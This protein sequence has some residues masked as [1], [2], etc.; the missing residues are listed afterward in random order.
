M[1]T[2]YKNEKCTK[3]KTVRWQIE[4]A[5]G[6]PERRLACALKDLELEETLLLRQIIN[7]HRMGQD[8][9]SLLR[10]TERQGDFVI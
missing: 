10:E 3:E 4:S 6:E 2:V 7:L 8:V 9:G 5:G 1:E